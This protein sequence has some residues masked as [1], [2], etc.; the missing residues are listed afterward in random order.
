[1]MWA[2]RNVSFVV[3]ELCV[4]CLNNGQCNYVLVNYNNYV[5]CGLS[6]VDY[7]ICVCD[8]IYE[9]CVS[10]VCNCETVVNVCV[11]LCKICDIYL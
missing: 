7:V 9:L 8:G 5:I 10:Y 11:L 3:Y 6:Y 1:M 2:K 4:L